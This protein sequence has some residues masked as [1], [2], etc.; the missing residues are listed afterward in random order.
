MSVGEQDSLFG[1]PARVEMWDK[2]SFGNSDEESEE[3]GTE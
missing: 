3:S 1:D 2:M